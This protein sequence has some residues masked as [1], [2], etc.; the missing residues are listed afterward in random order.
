MQWG[1]IKTLFILSFLLLN[2]YL[3]IQFSNKLSESDIPFLENGEPSLEETLQSENIEL[4]DLSQEV[5]ES[6]YISASPKKFTDKEIDDLN[7]NDNLD[8]TSIQD[9][10]TNL[11][12]GQFE[13]PVP[14]PEDAT[15]EAVTSIV[16]PYVVAGSEYEYWQWNK[17][18]NII[19]F[20]Q[21]KDGKVVYRNEDAILLFFLNEDNQITHYTQTMLG[22]IKKEQSETIL[23]PLQAIGRLYDNGH[24]SQ[25]EKVEQVELGYLSRI[26][27]EWGG[28]QVFAPTWNVTIENENSQDD[29]FVNAIEGLIYADSELV[30]LKKT[31]DDYINMVRILPDDNELKESTLEVL[32]QRLET[33]NRSETE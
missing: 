12:V 9:N 33:E 10:A 13:E 31:I 1:H 3:F 5:T 29:Y 22:E 24:L 21:E 30:F 4:P 14:I 32:N 20:S 8:A 16:Q 26:Q 2:I 19:I 23:T 28:N 27:S 15:E 7:K 17:D 25:N 6:N 11:I 18:L